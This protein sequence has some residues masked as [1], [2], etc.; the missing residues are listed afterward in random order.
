MKHPTPKSLRLPNLRREP[1]SAIKQLR[2]SSD[3][4]GSPLSICHDPFGEAT[5][6]KIQQNHEK[7]LN[8]A[9]D[10]KIMFK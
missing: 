8:E 2:E 10:P 6:K 4:G 5:P 1:H 7:C 3:V 9:P